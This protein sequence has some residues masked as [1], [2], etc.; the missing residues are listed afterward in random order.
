VSGHEGKSQLQMMRRM[1]DKGSDRP[2]ID[3]Y[4][5]FLGRRSGSLILVQCKWMDMSRMMTSEFL[6]GDRCQSD[7]DRQLLYRERTLD[8]VQCKTNNLQDQAGDQD[9]Q[10]QI[11]NQKSN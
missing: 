6:R 4:Q 1:W 9:G 8:I 7:R 10:S 11:K 2:R 3:P 5:R